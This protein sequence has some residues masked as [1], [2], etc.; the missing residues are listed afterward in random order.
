MADIVNN[1][2]DAIGS[3]ANYFKSHGWVPDGTVTV[4]ATVTADY[5]VDMANQKLRP[6]L[7]VAELNDHGFIPSSKIAMTSLQQRCV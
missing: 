3:V 2:V 4:T 1:P 7:T 5:K 6:K